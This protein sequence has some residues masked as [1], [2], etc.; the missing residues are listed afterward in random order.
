M[1]N[2]I[3]DPFKAVSE[4]R[5]DVLEPVSCLMQIGEATDVS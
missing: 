2:P 3:T 4:G 1:M 5:G